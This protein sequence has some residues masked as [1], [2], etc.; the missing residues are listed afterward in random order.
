MIPKPVILFTKLLTQ[1]WPPTLMRD[2]LVNTLKKTRK[3]FHGAKRDS[4]CFVV[5]DSERSE[6]EGRVQLQP[7][8]WK[9][10]ARRHGF[11][12]ETI[13]LNIWVWQISHKKFQSSSSKNIQQRT[14]WKKKILPAKAQFLFFLVVKWTVFDTKLR[15]YAVQL[16]TKQPVSIFLL[17]SHG[18]ID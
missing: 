11:N 18:V 17:N 3:V 15:Q 4:K 6:V 8:D 10:Y 12:E 14:S 7:E 2:K 1:E 16:G 13:E 5:S 9:L